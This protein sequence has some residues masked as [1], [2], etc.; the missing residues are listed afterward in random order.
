MIGISS[1]AET[2]S[3]TSME[4]SNSGMVVTTTSLG[5]IVG[6]T[7][8]LSS[9]TQLDSLQRTDVTPSTPAERFLIPATV[10]SSQ[11]SPTTT[12]GTMI[13]IFQSCRH[14][15]TRGRLRLKAIYVL[16]SNS[17]NIIYIPNN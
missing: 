2:T 9:D 4:L 1:P 11:P 13:Y 15:D 14:H 3:Q 12:T 10:T 5:S 7:R 16:Y 6:T 8:V 17:G